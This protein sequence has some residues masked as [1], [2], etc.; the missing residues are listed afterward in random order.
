MSTSITTFPRPPKA[1][2]AL[3]ITPNSTP[4]EVQRFL[5]ATLK[6]FVVRNKLAGDELIG[7]VER[8]PEAVQR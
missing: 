3:S 2:Q 5:H 8:G 4:E 1:L 6:N 7:L